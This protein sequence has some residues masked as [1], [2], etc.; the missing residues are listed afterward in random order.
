M[1]YTID[2]DKKKEGVDVTTNVATLKDDLEING[3][4]TEFVNLRTTGW[5]QVSFT[6]TC[7]FLLSNLS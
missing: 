5:V 3:M 7:V 1:S 2:K 4:D 6:L